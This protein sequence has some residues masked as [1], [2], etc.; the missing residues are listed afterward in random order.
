[1]GF[2][3]FTPIVS[4]RKLLYHDYTMNGIIILDQ[5][6]S[7]LF[8]D[9]LPHT[10]IVETLFSIASAVGG[11]V[12]LWLAI[13]TILFI[14]EERKDH[15]FFAYF[16]GAFVTTW[17]LVDQ[18]LKNLMW[19]ARPYLDLGLSNGVCPLNSSFPSGHAATAFSAAVVLSHFDK[20][21]AWLYYLGAVIVSYSRIYLYCHYMGDVVIGAVIGTLI[22][23]LI[24]KIPFPKKLRRSS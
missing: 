20:K 1:M 2:T 11:S 10:F 4:R 9:L 12:F 14:I 15:H 7:R 17:I 23:I 6:L 19:R 5:S 21:R 18:I 8:G 3:L 22:S 24:L 16:I 13:I